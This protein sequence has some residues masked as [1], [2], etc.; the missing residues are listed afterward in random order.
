MYISLTTIVL[1]AL[2]LFF[3]ASWRR[4]SFEHSLSL[5][6]KNK[7]ISEAQS[8]VD[9]MKDISW[10]DMSEKQRELQECAA[11]RLKLL[12]SYKKNHAPD[13]FTGLREW[14]LWF[15]INDDIDKL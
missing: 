6:K 15:S 5:R 4:V 8:V 1:L 10:G 12:L 14:P 13:H 2:A 7:M 3:C 9:A 11:E